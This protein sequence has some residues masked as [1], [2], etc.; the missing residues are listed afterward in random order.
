MKK[1][2]A[3]VMAMIMMLC[4]GAVAFAETNETAYALDP[5]QHLSWEN[6]TSAEGI[7]PVLE[8]GQFNNLDKYG[9]KMW[10]PGSMKAVESDVYA[11]EYANADGSLHFMVR[12]EEKPENLNTTEAL[13]EHL[14]GTADGGAVYPSTINDMFCLVFSKDNASVIVFPGEDKVVS[15]V[16]TNMADTNA[17]SFNK[18]MMASLQK[19]DK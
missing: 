18:V 1:L 3:A 13:F 7:A 12:E 10:I 11:Y 4:V 14:K 15:F 19:A 6:I 9:L 5:Q 17:S 16:F 2:I 8:Q